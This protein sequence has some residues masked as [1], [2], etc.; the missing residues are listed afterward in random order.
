M[1]SLIASRFLNEHLVV[2]PGYTQ[3]LRI[4][5]LR[6]EELAVAPDAVCPQWLVDATKRR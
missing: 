3:G 6:H 2:R 5:E 1:H 4:G